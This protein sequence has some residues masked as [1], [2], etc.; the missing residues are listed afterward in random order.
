[1]VWATGRLVDLDRLEPALE[2][3]V[4]LEVLAV[5]V[6]RGG[7]DGLQLAAG[8][9]RLEDAGGVDRALGRAGADERVELVDEQDDVAAGADLL[10]HLLEALLEV[11][12]VTGA[13]DER[14]EVE[15]VELLA[16]ERLGHVAVDDVGREA[17]DDGGLA[18]ARLADQHRVVLGAPRQHLHHPL[19]LLLATDHRVELLV[20]GELGEVAAELVEDER[21]AG[22]RLAGA[23]ALGRALLAAGVAGQQLDD[24]LADARQV[25][26]QLH[27]HLGGDAFAFAD[28][29][30]E[31]VLGADVVVAELQR[32]AEAQLQ[33]LLGA[34]CERDVPG[35]RR[36]TVTDD[37]LH[38][39]AHGFER[40]AERL[41][42]LGRDAL[43]LVDQT[44][45]DVLGA[46][47]VVV[48]QPRLFLR[49]H[50]HSSGSIG[51]TFEHLSTTSREQFSV[52]ISLYPIRHRERLRTLTPVFSVSGRS[53][54]SGLYQTA[55]PPESLHLPECS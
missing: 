13:G 31:D 6:E 43:T 37:L 9:H 40:D 16:D 38:L 21:A 50:D 3:G 24:L 23:G 41:E 10:E 48:E 14:A 15:R 4:L 18:D 30:E 39:G 55:P 46:D 8:Q 1:M 27:E 25:G 53:R 7:A 45:Q 54:N 52:R 42:R 26:A 51:E 11:A 5:L 12:A 36:A 35:R 33:D 29:P 32:F 44:E 47:V 17:F 22:L 19:D 28:Q 34:R 2:G 20:A 49:Q